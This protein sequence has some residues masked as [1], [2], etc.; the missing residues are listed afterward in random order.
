MELAGLTIHALHDKLVNGEVSAT[1][2]TEAVLQRLEALE[3]R[4]HAYITVTPELARQ[5]AAAADEALA[6]GEVCSPLQGIPLAIKDNIC[7]TGVRTT[8]ASRLLANFVPPYDATVMQRLRAAGAVCIG[9][10]NMDEFAMGSSTE[11]SAFGPTRNPWGGFNYVPGGSSGGPA[12]AVAADLCIAALGSDTGGSIRLPA[13][14]TGVVGLKPT[15]GRVSRFGLVAFASSLDQ[16]GP[17]TKDVQDAALLL[18]AIAGHDPYDST[19][20]A[21]PV[22]DYRQ[23]LARGV[24]GLK[25]GVPREYFVA[26]MDAEVEHAVRAGIETLRELGAELV[27]VSL[28]HTRYAVAT[29]Y[30]LA[31]AEASSNLARY[32]G[33]RYGVRASQAANLLDMYMRTR[34]EGFGAEV[35]RR[36]MLGTYALSAGYYDAY[37]KKAQQ[38]RTLFRQDFQQAFTQCD[39]LLAPV[40]PTP[41]FRLGERLADPLQMYLADVFTIPVNLAG[42]PALSVPCE[43]TRQELPIGLQMIAPPFREDT[44][45]QVAAA[46]EAVT[47]F[48]TRK[49]RLAVGAGE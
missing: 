36:I 14:M 16:I 49:P 27:D 5:Q 31:N 13:A 19:S 28:P 8:C 9:K 21:V 45:L 46:F 29:Y 24:R 39:A 42:L 43:L 35:K 33:V 32:D 2:L 47:D 4:V 44:L 22:P 37:Y 17:L 10:A 30:I 7:T 6:R 34:A 40:A 15:Y 48:H 12:A 11:N 3:E 38:L 1:A 23:A 20:A 26:G 41:A 25:L 18:Q